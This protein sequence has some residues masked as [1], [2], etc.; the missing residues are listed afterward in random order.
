MATTGYEIA[1]EAYIHMDERTEKYID[2][3]WIAWQIITY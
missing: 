1:N 3:A 2:K